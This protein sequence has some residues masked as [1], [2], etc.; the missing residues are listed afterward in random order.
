L[1][2]KQRTSVGRD[3]PSLPSPAPAN[4]EKPRS[5]AHITAHPQRGH[6]FEN[7]VMT[8]LLKA[9]T[10]RGIKPTLH[11]LRDKEGHEIDA[12]I[13]TGP[14][15]FQAVEIKSGE[16]VAADFFSGLDYWRSRL[17]KQSLTPWLIHGGTARQDREK[18]TVLP[19]NNLSSLLGH[20]G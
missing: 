4:P 11:F 16:T 7:W 9:Q 12:L 6:L 3:F 15:T 17:T 2:P 13:A 14:D 5:P 20:L 19:W 8:E 18:A 1:Q 10:N